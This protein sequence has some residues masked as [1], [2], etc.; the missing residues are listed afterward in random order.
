MAHYYG[1]LQGQAGEATRLGNKRSGLTTVA[2]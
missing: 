2:A 1:T